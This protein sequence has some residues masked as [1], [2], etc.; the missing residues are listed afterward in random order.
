MGTYDRG[1][2]NY[3]F[4]TFLANIHTSFGFANEKMY[5]IFP[6]DLE[7]TNQKLDSDELVRNHSYKTSFCIRNG[8]ME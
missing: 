2:N 6:E 7:K 8:F 4:S 1:R 3:P 5:F